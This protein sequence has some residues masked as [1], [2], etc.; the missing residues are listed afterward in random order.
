MSK[1]N[2]FSCSTISVIGKGQQDK[3][4]KDIHMLKVNVER[5]ISRVLFG[6]GLPQLD[7]VRKLIANKI[8]RVQ[9]WLRVSSKYNTIGKLTPIIIYIYLTLH[10]FRIN[11][12]NL[13]SDSR[14]SQSELYNFLYKLNNH[15]CRLYS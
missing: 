11:K 7:E 8:I 10:N 13:L 2:L 6:L 14:I 12:S 4:N 3:V 5:E 1:C 9:H 15:I